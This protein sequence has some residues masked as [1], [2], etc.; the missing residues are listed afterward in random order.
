[1]G[2]V[3]ADGL[4]RSLRAG[5]W[6]SPQ[7]AP[8]RAEP[9]EISS[10]ACLG[11]AQ[12]GT[13][14]GVRV[15][16]LGVGEVVRERVL[17][18]VLMMAIC[19]VAACTEADGES[20]PGSSAPSTVVTSTSPSSVA[21]ATSRSTPTAG[22]PASSTTTPAPVVG[23]NEVAAL[24][25]LEAWRAADEDVMRA[26]GDAGAVDAALGIGRPV[27]DGFTRCDSQAKWPVRVLR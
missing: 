24:R 17:L 20:S 10:S 9:P 23:P 1:M 7:R 16:R 4:S 3:P 14:N 26:V 19:P 25:F 21:S 8:E 18:G 13:I 15:V 5:R 11:P 2:A 22:S 27:G 6:W 12:A